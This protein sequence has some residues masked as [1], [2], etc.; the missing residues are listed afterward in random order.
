MNKIKNNFNF[1]KTALRDFKVGALTPSSRY[2]VKKIIKEI[3]PDYK[4]I[5]EYGPGDG[6]VTKAILNILPSDGRLIAIEL[7]E[8]FVGQLKKIKDDRL[9]IIYG[10]VVEV[11][12]KLKKLNL[13]QIDAV[14]S[15]IPCSILT[16][17]ER[18]ELVKNT[19][20]SLV[21]SGIFLIYQSIPIVFLE[22]N[23]FFRKNITWRFE[24]RNFTPYFILIAKKDK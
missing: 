12:K 23:K 21:K 11:S 10:N 13:P 6:V 9:I 22:L 17:K 20:N 8:S 1:L 24:P 14:I 5:V 15:G 19:Y 3:K 7:N 16:S 4:Y 18:E 2:V